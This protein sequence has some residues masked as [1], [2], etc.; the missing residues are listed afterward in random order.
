LSTT[1][2]RWAAPISTPVMA[3]Y[4]VFD[5]RVKQMQKDRAASLEDGK[6]SRVVD[7]LRDEVADTMLERFLVRIP[8]NT[9]D[10]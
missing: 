3:P 6:P 5:R 9:L 2:R 1:S 4:Q 10:V 7:Y 8:V